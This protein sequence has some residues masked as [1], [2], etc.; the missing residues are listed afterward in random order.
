MSFARASRLEIST[1]EDVGYDRFYAILQKID[2]DLF[3]PHFGIKP[4]AK[5][6]KVYKWFDRITWDRIFTQA[7]LYVFLRQLD[8]VVQPGDTQATIYK[9]RG[10]AYLL[11]MRWTKLGRYYTKYYKSCI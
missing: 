6:E 5:V 11:M 3:K 2:N 4:A 1:P 10:A 7:K 8:N 9:A